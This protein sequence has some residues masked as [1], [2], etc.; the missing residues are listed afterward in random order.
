MNADQEKVVR[1]FLLAAR[2]RHLAEIARLDVIL[3]R[4]GAYPLP[5]KTPAACLEVLRW[6]GGPMGPADVTNELRAHGH[7]VTDE[8]VHTALCRL[9]KAG[10]VE[11]VCHGRYILK[12]DAPR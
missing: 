4:I 9:A 12:G 3:A 6:H 11:R 8:A 7:H 5:K 10:K 1:E 2:A